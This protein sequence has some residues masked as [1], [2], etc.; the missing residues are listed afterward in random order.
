MQRFATSHEL[1]NQIKSVLT[2]CNIGE[3]YVRMLDYTIELFETQ[4]LGTDYYGYHNIDH[5]L[6]VAYGVLLMGRHYLEK[7]EMTVRQVQYMFAAALLHDFDPQK[8][9]DKPHESSVINYIT[10]DKNLGTLVREADLDMEIIKILILRTTYPWKGPHK[11][12]ASKDI[13]ECF[14]RSTIRDSPGRQEEVMQMGW[15]LSVTDRIA[16]YAMGDFNRS[17]ELAKINAHASAWHPSLI[18]CR[19][20]AYFEDLLNSESDMLA[21]VLKA[22]PKN[23]RKGFFETVQGFMALRQ[24]EIKI[25][26]KYVF[27]NLKL[28]PV[29]ENSV[30]RND[31]K[32]IESLRAI[33]EELPR[34]LQF[35]KDRFAESIRDPRYILNTLHLN[36]P[37]G[38]IVGFAKGGALELYDL[39][40]EVKDENRGL[41]NTVFLEPLSIKMG[42]WGMGGGSEMRHMFVM[43]AH[44]MKFKYLT[45]FALRDV[46]RKRKESQEDVEFVTLFDPERWDYYRINI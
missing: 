4:G 27:E 36:S 13:A 18:V 37:D 22:F 35:T 7:G 1:R 2:S 5:E 42:Y 28:V 3:T 12:N 15:L 6:E 41:G 16:G 46:I 34:P 8:T 11:I 45:S 44:A 23:M 9:V 20:V 39:R 31:Q 40:P 29:I 10:L 25:Q 30:S 19:S 17:V 26:A 24:E 21:C 38:E 33:Y 43:Q 14:K 32:F